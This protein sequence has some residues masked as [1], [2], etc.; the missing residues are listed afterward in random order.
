MSEQSGAQP[1]QYELALSAEEAGNGTRKILPRNGK[2][3]EVNIPPGVITGSTVKLTNA[4]QLT[5]GITGDILIRVR[6][7]E[8]PASQETFASETTPAGVTEVTDNSFEA[9]VIKAAQ[10]AV[11]DFWAPWCGPCKM[12]APVM[13]NLAEIYKGK[14][15]FCKIN[16]DENPLAA[17]RFNAMSIPMLLFFQN[18]QAVDQSVGA[19]P[20]NQ[21]QAKLDAWL[22]K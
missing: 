3:L 5:D 19:I 14:V 17:R 4:L 16:V 20:Q 10:P 9:E 12:M 7:K 8:E 21:I 6:V 15:K 1:V 2:R 11:V 22:G 13:E 18:G